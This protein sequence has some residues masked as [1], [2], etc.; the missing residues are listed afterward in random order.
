MN[1]VINRRQAICGSIWIAIFCIAIVLWPLRLI[2]ETVVS[3]GSGQIV[4]ESQAITTDYVVKQRFIAQYDKLKSIR[5]YLLNESAGEEFYFV[6]YDSDM[7]IL[8]QQAVSTDNMEEMPGYCTVPLNQELEVGKDYYFLIQGITTDF[9]VAYEDNA[10][11]GNVYISTLY[12]GSIEDNEHSVIAQYDYTVPLR[13]GKTFLVDALLVLFGLL[14]T[15]LTGKYYK[16]KPQNNTLLT[17]E[18]AFRIVMS[19]LVAAVG[20][21]GMITVWPLKLYTDN[22][23]SLI[24]YEASILLA[25]LLALYGINHTREHKRTDLGFPVI[26][27]RW[28][29]WLQALF[30]AGAIQAC[31]HYMNGLY[32]IHHTLAYREMLI[33]FGLAVIVT[34]KRKELFNLV[35]LIYLPIAAFI[36]Y[37]YY[38]NNI[39]GLEKPEDIEVVKLTVWVGI[40]TGIILI[41]TI[42]ILVRGRVRGISPFYGILV[43]VFFVLLIVYRN[44]RGWPVYL[45]CA[46]TLYYLRMAAWEKKERLLLNICNG[47]LL[48]FLLMMLYCLWHRPYMYYIYYRYPFTFHTVTMTAVYLALVV[49]AALVKVLDAYRRSPKL[50][51]VW[52]ELLVFGFSSVY[53][54][55][56][57]SRTGYLAVLVMAVIAIPIICLT[58]KKKFRAMGHVIALLCLAAVLCFPVTFTA[59]RIIP[60][61]V[62]QPKLHE[63]EELPD[64]I[65]H[66]RVTD[67]RYYINIQRLIQVFQMKVLGMPEEKCI[68]AHS[69]VK[70]NVIE[71]FSDGM[72]LASAEDGGSGIPPEETTEQQSDAQSY[73]N[74]RL[75]IFEL[76]YENLNRNGHDDMYITLPDGSLVVHAHNIYL[77]VAYDHGIFVGIVFILVGIGTF[78]QGILYFI[79]KRDTRACAALPFV[80][81]LLFAVAGLTEWI[82]HPCNPIAYCLLLT[83]APLLFDM[84]KSGGRN[85]INEKEKEKTL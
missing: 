67:S 81:L 50:S 20:A 43:T 40:L 22:V 35:N 16:K 52:K 55:F 83:L 46:F 29:D 44:T 63:I 56:T 27:D 49:G 18:K 9:Y 21:V 76:Y 66:G 79:R 25:V 33:Y 19:P 15:V 74:G 23:P 34:Y 78:I 65:M 85:G 26:Q 41:N 62:A 32:E 42:W 1:K 14:I 45:V 5:I 77:Q 47:I 57:L 51:G 13:K 39:I 37:H 75:E 3:R 68:E 82:F 6:L 60:S 59:Q 80:I 11:S 58:M 8:L 31:C 17:V 2:N 69:I 4:M 72:L 61:V 73:A 70:N 64:E 28:S 12:Y 10:A 71:K 48:H 53:L 24:F 54:L 36:G 84:K 38:Q 30:F 7:N